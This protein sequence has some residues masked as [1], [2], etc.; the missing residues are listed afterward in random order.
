MV[1][2]WGA[3]TTEI[4]PPY[5]RRLF[6]ALGALLVNPLPNTRT[7][8]VGATVTRAVGLGGRIEKDTTEIRSAGGFAV[9]SD[10]QGAP[11]AIH[12]KK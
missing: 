9:L 2:K 3:G 12:P 1:G 8:D 5:G 6:A 11:F 4:V 7:T 10:P